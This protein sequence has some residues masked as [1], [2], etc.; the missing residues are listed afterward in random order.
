MSPVRLLEALTHRVLL[1]DGAMG[2]QLQM[3]GLE[4]G[5]PPVGRQAEGRAGV[6]RA[7]GGLGGLAEPGAG[8]PHDVHEHHPDW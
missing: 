7:A 8:R 6:P 3:A 4:P 2:T 5:G 1:S